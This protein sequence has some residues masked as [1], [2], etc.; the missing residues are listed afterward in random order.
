MRSSVVLPQRYIENLRSRWLATPRGADYRSRSSADLQKYANQLLQV[1]SILKPQM[2]P[3]EARN[4]SSL[5]QLI[6][7]DLQVVSQRL[8]MADQTI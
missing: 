1:S 5:L 2:D 4:A 8:K 3:A 6:A 7:D